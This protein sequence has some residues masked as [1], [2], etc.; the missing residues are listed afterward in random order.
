MNINSHR[1]SV[2]FCCRSEMKSLQLRAFQIISQTTGYSRKQLGNLNDSSIMFIKSCF[3]R[4]TKL[5]QAKGSG[6]HHWRRASF[7]MR[8]YSRRLPWK[9][10]Q[11]EIVVSSSIQAEF[12]QRPWLQRLVRQC[13]W[14]QDNLSTHCDMSVAL[15]NATCTSLL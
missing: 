6:M 12:N 15:A 9:L 4:R 1:E 11:Q 7:G 3:Q 14:L 13:E 8:F 10:L 5:S 2:F